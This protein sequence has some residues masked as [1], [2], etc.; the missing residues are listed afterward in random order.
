[1]AIVACD[2]FVSVMATIQVLYVCIAMEIGSRRIL[3]GGVAKYPWGGVDHTVP[4][5]SGLNERHLRRILRDFASPKTSVLGGLHH[6]Y[7]LGKE[8]A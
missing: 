6:D 8:A 3:H 2:F 1:M 5:D 7:R 4:R